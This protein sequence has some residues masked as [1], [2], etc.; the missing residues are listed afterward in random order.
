M[1]EAFVPCKD[2]IYSFILYV[3]FD[4][5]ALEQKIKDTYTKKHKH[6]NLL[7]TYNINIWFLVSS[8]L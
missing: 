5:S 7:H 8:Q 1:S 6:L 3:I 4:P 2:Y